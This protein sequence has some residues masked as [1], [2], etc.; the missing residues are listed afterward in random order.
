M[1]FVL[2]KNCN[3]FIFL[4]FDTSLYN[5]FSLIWEIHEIL[6]VSHDDCNGVIIDYTPTNQAISLAGDYMF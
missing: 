5:T 2:F 4:A 6:F 1:C 3:K